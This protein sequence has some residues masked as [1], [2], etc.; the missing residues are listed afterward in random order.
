MSFC[1]SAKNESVYQTIGHNDM[2][3]VQCVILSPASQIKVSYLRACIICPIF[4]ATN[5]FIFL[6]CLE[7]NWNMKSLSPSTPSNKIH[8]QNLMLYLWRVLGPWTSLMEAIIINS[9]IVHYY[10]YNSCIIIVIICDLYVN[11]V[12]LD[13]AFMS[14]LCTYKCFKEIRFSS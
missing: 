5:A 14:D 2:R 3:L 10:Y 12:I 8:I 7:R 1:F 11:K 9:I 13:L 6:W 4:C